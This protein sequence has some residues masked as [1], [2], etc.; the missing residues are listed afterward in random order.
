MP[1]QTRHRILFV[2]TN[3]TWGGSEELWS[4]TAIAL[5]RE[6]HE[7]AAFKMLRG[8]GNRAMSDLR[9]LGGR[10]VEVARI[11]LVPR[12][13]FSGLVRYAMPVA[14]RVQ[15]LRLRGLIATMSRPDLVVLSQGSNFDALFLTSIVRSL[16]L[17]YALIA[18]KATDQRWPEDRVRPSMQ[19][20]YEGAVETFFVSEHTRRLTE[21][22]LGVTLSN[23]SIVRNPFA[24]SY[25]PR[26]DWPAADVLK[27]ACVGRLL[28]VEKGQDLLLRVL[29][30]PHWRER[31]ISVT[32]Y[33]DGP[34]RQGLESLARRYQL[35][36]VRFAGVV[37]GAEEIWRDHHALVLPSRAEGLPLA[38][39]EAMLSGRVPIVTNAGGNAEVIQ[40]DRTGF[41][42]AAAS[43]EALDEAMSRAWN[44]RDDWPSIGALAAEEIRR[45]I[46]ADPPAVFAARLL[47]LARDRRSGA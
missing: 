27:L 8:T 46:P 24:V 38:I 13:A 45:V 41:V 21:E 31:A 20:A 14:E 6:G 11:P 44:R 16:G 42:A 19:S 40:N 7:I 2:S 29:A 17:P 23:T 10:V 22:Q 5:A 30:R 32:F 12:R 47:A 43:E 18:H 9:D 33:G 25:V 15:E 34:H 4:R 36:N 26:T 1:A 3:M 28:P 39:V 35:R 37:D